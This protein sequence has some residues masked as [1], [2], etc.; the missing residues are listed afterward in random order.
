MVTVTRIYISNFSPTGF[1]R[2][3]GSN[4]CTI[5]NVQVGENNHNIHV[6]GL[7]INDGS[8]YNVVLSSMRGRQFSFYYPW[9]V[10]ILGPSGASNSN[11][12]D[13]AH[14]PLDIKLSVNSFNFT[15]GT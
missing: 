5:A 8:G 12:T 1:I 14:G 13:T 9:P 11:D 15:Q 6:T 4:V 3:S 7:T 10:N 2:C